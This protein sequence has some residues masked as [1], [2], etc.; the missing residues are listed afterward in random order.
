[1]IKTFV[2]PNT[3]N[4]AKELAYDIDGDS[5]VDNAFG[6]ILTA[7]HDAATGVD[8]EA[9]IN[10][11]VLNG[12]DVGLLR[13]TA[14]DYSNDDKATIQGWTGKRETCCAAKP[15]KDDTANKCFTGS[16]KFTVDPNSPKNATLDGAIKSGSFEFTGKIEMELPIGENRAKVTLMAAKFTGKLGGSGITDGK[17]MGAVSKND[18]ETS[19]IPAVAKTLNHEMNDATTK[20]STKD[21][22]KKEFD[23]N[24]DGTISTQEVSGNAKVQ[25]VLSGAY[26]DADKDG[27]KEE[28]SL[29]MGFTAVGAAL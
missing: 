20:Q 16:F 1:M 3:N 10:Q 6:A 26:I 2:L 12:N 17:I 25:G 22:L 9:E 13:I 23:T 21:A 28:L 24:N 5:K 27:K 19:L 7:I 14:K 15:C 8:M 18:I 29:G 11:N 4:K